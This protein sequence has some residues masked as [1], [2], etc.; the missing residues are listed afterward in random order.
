M[1]RLINKYLDD[2]YLFEKN[3]EVKTLVQIAKYADKMYY[4]S[5]TPVLSDQEYDLLRELIFNK[6][7]KNKY[8]L[9]TGTSV[10]KV[11]KVKITLPYVLGSMFKPTATKVEKFIETFKIKFPGPY[12]ISEK[13]DGVSALLRIQNKSKHELMTKGNSIIGTNI[14]NLIP[15]LIKTKTNISMDIRGEIIM[16]KKT[17]LINHSKSR[18]DSRSTVAGLVNSKTVSQSVLKDSQFVAYEILKPWLP[19]DQQMNIL[20]K[21]NGSVVKSILIENF[22]L[23]FLKTT[24]K[25]FVRDSDYECDGIIITQNSPLKRDNSKYP[26]YAFAFKNMDDLESKIIKIKNIVWQIS[27]DGLIKPVIKFD[28]IQLA[29]V[30]IKS[31]TSHNAKYIFD[32]N[33][34]PGAQIEIVRSGGVIPYVKRIVKQASEPQMPTIDY[35]WN[36]TE[37]D[38]ITTEYSSEQKLKEL[39]KFF[40]G[41]GV[42]NLAM[43]NTKKII[44]ANIDTIPKI[45]KVTKRQLTT[46]AQF[47]TKMVNK[48]FNS[49]TEKISEMTLPMFMVASNIFGHGFGKRLMTK[50]FNTYPNIFF[51]YIEL[52]ENDFFEL[53][54]DIDGFAEERSRQFQESMEILLNVIGQLPQNVQDNLIFTIYHSVNEEDDRFSGNKFVFSGKRNIEW[55]KIIT[56]KGGEVLTSVSKNTFAVI[57]TQDV[58]D[59]D[60]NNKI[61]LA[62][63]YGCRLLNH[64]EFQNEFI[65]EL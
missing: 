25:N 26:K 20:K 62:K 57:T 17:F 31:V 64:E 46:V 41:I 7:P 10:E 22:D 16:D 36:F 44:D 34:G 13:L 61:I 14:S 50:V 51:K 8:L 52:N 49:I 6:D 63:K 18:S 60:T 35:D 5:E 28:P 29:G 30:N 65:N 12:L 39:V 21:L 9:E 53:L 15:G 3:N 40:K 33:L 42:E 58:I 38:I 47:K 48:I 11:E 54:M 2:P 19:F 55:E 59:Q 43:S 37:V 23:D 45:I 24:F 1:S 4:N 27:K 32:N 56:N